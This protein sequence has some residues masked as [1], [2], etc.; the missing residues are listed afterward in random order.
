MG[1]SHNSEQSLQSW[2]SKRH[3][4]MPFINNNLCI[5]TNAFIL[6][7]LWKMLERWICMWFRKTGRS[8][9]PI[10]VESLIICF[11]LYHMH[12]SYQIS[13]G[14]LHLPLTVHRYSAWYSCLTDSCS[15]IHNPFGWI[16]WQT[17]VWKEIIII[18]SVL[19]SACLLCSCFLLFSWQTYQDLV[20]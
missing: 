9:R 10:Q 4:P 2:P 19:V 18:F 17:P 12:V 15:I 16:G 5:N 1:H 14:I 3:Y 7:V 20:N 13:H 8:S 11:G 6:V